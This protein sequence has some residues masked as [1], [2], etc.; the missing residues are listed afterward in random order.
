MTE[1]EIALRIPI[2]QRP[3][4]DELYSVYRRAFNLLYKSQLSLK[5]L[6]RIFPEIHSALLD[7]ARID[8]R[9]FFN[10][11]RKSKAWPKELRPRHI[12][13]DEEHA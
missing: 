12:K 4:L 3:E 13:F 9:Q 2:E 11:V 5:S 8:E 6:K 1:Q 7:N 10:A